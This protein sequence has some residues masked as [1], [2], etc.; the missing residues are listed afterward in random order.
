MKRSLHKAGHVSPFRD[1]TGFNETRF[2]ALLTGHVFPFRDMIGLKK[3]VFPLFRM[4]RRG[5]QTT[6]LQA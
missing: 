5:L 4:L 1:M 2:P 3:H 6:C